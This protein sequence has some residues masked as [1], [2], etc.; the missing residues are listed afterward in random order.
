M[1]N[2]KLA[3]FPQSPEDHKRIRGDKF[4]PSKKYPEFSG[5]VNVASSDLPALLKYLTQATPDY[6]DYNKQEVIPLRASGY[7]NTS[8][9]G[10]KYLALQITSDYKK[11]KEVDEGKSISAN[12][13]AA[14]PA[15]PETSQENSNW[16]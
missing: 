12:K 1:F 10:K 14:K 5:I 16:F 7:M 4:D 3:V 11:Q 15:V 2:L 6:D 8:K 9:G 13:D